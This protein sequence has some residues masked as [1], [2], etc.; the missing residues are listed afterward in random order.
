MHWI[1]HH[2]GQEFA[3][4]TILTR[5]K[6][7]V[8]GTI[9]IDDKPSVSGVMQPEWEH[10]LF[11]QPYNRKVTNRRRLNWSNYREILGI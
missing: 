3:E 6:T 5:D 9:L 7:L 11:D 10:V 2:L 4:R 8:R 1:R